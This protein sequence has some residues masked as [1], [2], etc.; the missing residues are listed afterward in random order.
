MN[1]I[2][3]VRGTTGSGKTTAIKQL[4]GYMRG[5][6]MLD[7]KGNIWAYNLQ[8]RIYA[9]GRYEIPTGGCDGIRTQAEVYA[10]IRK[11][12]A[13]GSVIFEG[14]L[15]SGMYAR[16][17]EL[18]EELKPT[19]HWI[20]A[21]LDTPL[22]KCIEQTVQRRAEKGNTKEFNPAHLEAKFSAVITTRVTL[23]NEGRDVRTLPHQHTLASLLDWL[24]ERAEPI[25]EVTQVA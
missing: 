19:H 1:I 4:I 21:C 25:V 17:R 15:I 6:P 23:E 18:E 11:L 10:G 13:L 9:L 16:Y 22:E 12:A 20:W 24:L 3:N 14:F 7:E 8:H 2:C 5:M